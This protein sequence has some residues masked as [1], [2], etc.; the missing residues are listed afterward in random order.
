MYKRIEREG[1]TIGNH[2]YSHNYKTVYSTID[3]FKADEKRLDDFLI[4]TIGHA[5]KILRFPGGS[6]NHVSY[7]YGGKGFMKKLTQ[8]IKKEGTV[9]FDWNVTSSDSDRLTKDK[10]SIINSALKEAKRTK[11]A[12]ILMHDSKPKTT[13]VE[14]LP[15]IIHGLKER[16]FKFA[17]LTPEVLP[18]QFE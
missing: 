2:T 15:A 1:H 10:Q 9:Y 5:P 17:P 4:S 16:G 3:G 7:G 13:T 14:A 11:K 8:E 12:I 18:V 6:N